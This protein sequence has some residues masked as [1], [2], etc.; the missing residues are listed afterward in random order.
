MLYRQA[1]ATINK[2]TLVLIDRSELTNKTWFFLLYT[3]WQN[4]SRFVQQSTCLSAV[5]F[6]LCFDAYSRI[7]F[8]VDYTD[9]SYVQ[10]LLITPLGYTLLLCHYFQLICKNWPKEAKYSFRYNHK[11]LQHISDLYDC[12]MMHYSPGHCLTL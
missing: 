2:S 4:Y 7:T 3:M 5:F 8:R 9:F 11:T 10:H 6:V 1:T 12:G